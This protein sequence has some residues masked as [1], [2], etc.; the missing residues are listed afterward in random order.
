MISTWVMA[1]ALTAGAHDWAPA[2]PPVA[3]DNGAE[4]HRVR[5]PA[6]AIPCRVDGT[7][8]VERVQLYVSDNR[9]KT[10]A[11]YE[12][13]APDK[14]AFIFT[15]KKPGEYWFTARLK[16]KDGTLDPADPAHFVPMQRVAVA[17]GTNYEP[18]TIAKP[19]SEI[20]NELDDE[21]TRLELDLIRKEMKRLAEAKDL[22][23]NTE[24][25]LDR[26][27]TRLR[28]VRDRLRRD[29]EADLGPSRG[30]PPSPYYPPDDRPF[31][32]DG[33]R[34]ESPLIPAPVLPV[35]PLPRV[36]EP[37]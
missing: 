21:L 12:E 3:T 22:G 18:P 13:I 7:K 26:L 31:P 2:T 8:A 11:L 34:V 1:A 10:W 24:E 4:V 16:K 36:P 27:R 30:L 9:G 17:T 20:A 32:P 5:G 15:A 25:K 23:P 37:R 6:F 28:D 19:T 14:G 35:A 33:P 29:R